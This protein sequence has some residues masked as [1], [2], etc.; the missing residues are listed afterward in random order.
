MMIELIPSF[1]HISY[2]LERD[3][4]NPAIEYFYSIVPSPRNT[5]QI[6]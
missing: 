6:S 5:Y 3:T 4:A 1:R 2:I